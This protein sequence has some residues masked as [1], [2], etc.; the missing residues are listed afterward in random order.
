M[1]QDFLYF[2]CSMVPTAMPFHGFVTVTLTGMHKIEGLLLLW[3]QLRIHFI[4][5]L[6]VVKNTKHFLQKNY[7]HL[8]REYF[9]SAKIARRHMLPDFPWEVM[10]H[11]IWDSAARI[12]MPR[13]RACREP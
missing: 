5:I 10:G 2:I 6:G 13:R 3:H 9:L 8:F 7:Q 4:R 1:K 12:F 11:G